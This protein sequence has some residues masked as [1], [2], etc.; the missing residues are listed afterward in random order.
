MGR[1]P[2][3]ARSG[4][5]CIRRPGPEIQLLTK[6]MTRDEIS[7]HGAWSQVQRQKKLTEPMCQSIVRRDPWAEMGHRASH[8]KKV[9]VRGF[10]PLKAYA[11]RFTVCPL[12]P[13]GYTPE[14]SAAEPPVPAWGTSH[15]S[16]TRASVHHSVLSGEWIRKQSKV[17]AVRPSVEFLLLPR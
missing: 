10:E 8:S 9:G 1:P 2:R 15:C 12:C 7:I 5:N 13:L 4:L 16:E 14:M 6:K 3:T 17:T 11:S